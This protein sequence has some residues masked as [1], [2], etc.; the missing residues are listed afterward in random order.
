MYGHICTVVPNYQQLT[1]KSD[2]RD[3][4]VSIARS[5]GIRKGNKE[6][7]KTKISCK[8]CCPRLGRLLGWHNGRNQHCLPEIHHLERRHFA[9]YK[10]SDCMHSAHEGTIVIE[11]D[12]ANENNRSC[13]HRDVLSAAS[14]MACVPL[15]HS[16]SSSFL[17]ISLSFVVLILSSGC[18]LNFWAGL[19]M[20]GFL[21]NRY[22]RQWDPLCC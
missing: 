15:A 1:S 18:D 6:K 8:N 17:C 11:W 4:F 13:C 20:L 9:P 19:S 14:L 12:R 21:H 7:S 2:F 16:F 5:I 22:Y 10:L 3:S